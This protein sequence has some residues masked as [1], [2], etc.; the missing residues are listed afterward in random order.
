MSKK[1]LEY[2]YLFCICLDGV[3]Q[4]FDVQ[5]SSVQFSTFCFSAVQCSAVQC[6][7]VQYNVT[8]V[9]TVQCAQCSADSAVQPG[10]SGGPT[11][12]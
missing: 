7:E 5:S 2:I 11:E 6:S 1:W 4:Q 9:S 12:L 3:V 10:G 8:Q